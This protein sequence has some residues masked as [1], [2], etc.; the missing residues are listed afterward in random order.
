MWPETLDINEEA[1][2]KNFVKPENVDL[3]SNIKCFYTK[4]NISENVLGFGVSVTRFYDSGIIQ[5][6]VST[7]DIL[8]L[9]A[10]LK[11]TRVSLSNESFTYFIPL[12]FGVEKERTLK[13]ASK[14]LSIICKDVS[15]GFEPTL[16]LE[17]LPKIISTLVLDIA[18][19]NIYYSQNVL[20]FMI[21]F[22]RLF[23]LFIQE[24]PE[25]M[26][27]MNEKIETFLSSEEN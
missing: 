12:Y 1:N 23:H 25:L 18:G 7:F 17:V 8:S 2:A 16:V 13:F 9:R 22:F 3:P 15:N 19:E 14:A 10:Y 4:M 6:V 26:T 5:N 27:M 20:K 21:Y 11:E 24:Y